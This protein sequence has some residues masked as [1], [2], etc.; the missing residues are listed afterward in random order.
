MPCDLPAGKPPRTKGSF[1]QIKTG[2]WKLFRKFSA[3]RTRKLL[4]RDSAASTFTHAYA[5]C[6]CYRHRYSE[7]DC[8]CDGNCNSYSNA[9]TYP[10]ANTNSTASPDSTAAPHPQASLDP[11]YSG[12]LSWRTLI[13]M[14][15]AFHRK[16]PTVWPQNTAT[17]L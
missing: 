1:A 15:A 9:Y 8:Y 3:T 6:Y 12:R 13:P 7:R 11:H 5:D 17:R 16:R 10:D 2:L 14:D 4:D